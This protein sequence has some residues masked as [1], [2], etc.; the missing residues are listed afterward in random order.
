LDMKHITYTLKKYANVV[1]LLFIDI[2]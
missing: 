2:N 1:L